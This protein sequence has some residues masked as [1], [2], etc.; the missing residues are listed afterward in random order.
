[1]MQVYFKQCSKCQST[2]AIECWENGNLI[3]RCNSCGHSSIK[4]V[5]TTTATSATASL[6]IDYQYVPILLNNA[7]VF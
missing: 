2:N 5:I 6:P 3:I 7:E 4:A 1:M